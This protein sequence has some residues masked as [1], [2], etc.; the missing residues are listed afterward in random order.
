MTCRDKIAHKH[1][2]IQVLQ[3]AIVS[4]VRI[5]IRQCVCV[6]MSHGIIRNP[7]MSELEFNI[8][9]KCWVFAQQVT[10]TV[11]MSWHTEVSR[12]YPESQNVRTRIQYLRE[13]LGFRSAGHIYRKK[14]CTLSRLY[15]KDYTNQEYRAFIELDSSDDLTCRNLLRYYFLVVVVSFFQTNSNSSTER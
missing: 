9:G 8:C 13:V 5:N 14:L 2:R 6:Q 12:Y 1:G 3:T 4:S 15:V 11:K 10:F 7:R